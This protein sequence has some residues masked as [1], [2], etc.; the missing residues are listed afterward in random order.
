MCVTSCGFAT[1][2]APE[3]DTGVLSRFLIGYSISGKSRQDG[4]VVTDGEV[5]MHKER[6]G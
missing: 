1:S 2:S 6:V 3:V 4:H 5:C